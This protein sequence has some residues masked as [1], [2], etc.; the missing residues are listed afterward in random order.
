MS[1][2]VGRTA[3]FS[4]VG[5]QKGIPPPTHSS[6]SSRSTGLP[7]TGTAHT[8]RGCRSELRGSV[9]TVYPARTVVM[10]FGLAVLGGDRAVDA[11]GRR[12]GRARDRPRQ[13]A[14]HGHLR[15][16]CHR[17]G[18]RG[19][20]H[21]L[22]W[23]RRRSRPRGSAGTA[24]GI[25]VTTFTVLAAAIVAEVR[26]N[27]ATE[28][29]GRRLAPAVLRQALTVALLGVGLIMAS[30]LFVLT[31]S[32]HRVE[33]VLYEVVSAFGTVGLS[34]G[35]TA[36]LPATGQLTLVVLMSTGRLGPITL[37]SALALRE[38]SRRNDLPEERPV[39]GWSLGFPA[40]TPSSPPRGGASTD[41]P[42]RPPGGRDRPR[43]LRQLTGRRVDAQRLG[44]E[45]DTQHVRRHRRRH[46]T[47]WAGLHPRHGRDLLEPGDVIVVTGKTSSVE[48]FAELV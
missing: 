25:K 31:V 7:R 15:G 18:P 28:A 13:R 27:P 34:T 35:I 16:L 9:F 39:I 23:F 26:G 6:C 38:R 10:A 37:V 19:H 2:K 1:T 22:E 44:R 17:P 41:T 21:P 48:A 4:V 20:S 47:R 24:G 12:R 8:G 14:V 45:P 36:D 43:P 5:G 40:P 46:Q 30:T 42:R 3:C 33:A 11:A 32:N 29:M